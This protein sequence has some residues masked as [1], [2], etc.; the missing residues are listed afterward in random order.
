MAIVE[1]GTDMLVAFTDPL[2]VNKDPGLVVPTPT[3]PLGN[4]V[5][6]VL[7]AACSVKLVADAL[8]NVLTVDSIVPGNCVSAIFYP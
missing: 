5:I 4:I 2:T 6:A 8:V 7:P 3:L 1:L